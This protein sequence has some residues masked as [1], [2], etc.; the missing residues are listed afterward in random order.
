[1]R[2]AAVWLG[3]LV[4]GGCVT[5][6]SA[7]GGGSGACVA[8]LPRADATLPAPIAITTRCGRFDLAR[9]G[10]V[11]RT[12]TDP[13][14][15]P[16]GVFSWWP[17]TGVWERLEHGRLVVGRWQRQLWR[18]HGHFPLAYQVDEIVIGARALAFSYGWRTPRLYLARFGGTE[19]RVASGEFPL[20]W[21]RDGLYT[22]RGRGGQLRLRT[23]DGALRQ[24]LARHVSTYAYDQAS[25]RLYFLAHGALMQAE[26]AHERRL[27]AVAGLALS[28]GR[29]LQLQPL[30][31]LVALLD[32][33]RLVVLGADGSWLAAT[34]LP[35]HRSRADGISSSIAAAPDG[36]AVAFTATRGNTAYRSHST[37]IVY[38]L[39]G[40][41]R[42]AVALHSER[43]DLAG[44]GRSAD[45]AWYGR[46][47]LYSASEGKLAVIDS[48]GAQ[49][50]I[51]LSRVLR[52]LPGTH[53]DDGSI[54]FN[55]AWAGVPNGT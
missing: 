49:R 46:W 33:R 31:R 27:A 25:G 11:R 6:G 19:R 42:R 15:V 50:T 32:T 12:S 45:L 14:P 4:I 34:R 17:S 1:M 35:R 3:L 5:A 10:R 53:G 28:P 36:R 8:R 9:D 47:L 39:R 18:S 23:E 26:G 43:V 22:R 41:E 38:L 24:T 21:T 51:D 2:A 20:G 48:S 40:G 54:D 29:P 16:Q 30:G 7:A 37:E 52:T 13:Q 55:A 44:C